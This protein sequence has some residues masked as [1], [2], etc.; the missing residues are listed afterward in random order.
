MKKWLLWF[1]VGCFS[2]QVVSA[3]SYLPERN[4]RRMLISPVIGLGAY[5]FNL[6]DVHLTGD[7]PFKHAMD[8]DGGYI[9]SLQP[10]RLLHRFFKNSGLMPKDSIYG[11]WESDGLSGH[12]LGHYLSTASMMYASA[13]AL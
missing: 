7:G 3:Q 2:L 11:G 1:A 5:G 13:M 12:T 10:D 4:N 8:I 6:R 9:L